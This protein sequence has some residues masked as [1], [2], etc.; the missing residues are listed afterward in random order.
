M[1]R[2]VNYMLAL[3]GL[4]AMASCSD[5]TEIQPKGEKSSFYNKATGNVA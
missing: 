3:S 2:I 1:K 5:F 4:F